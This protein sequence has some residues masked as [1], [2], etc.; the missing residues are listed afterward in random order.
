MDYKVSLL[1]TST[2]YPV[3]KQ[4]LTDKAYVLFLYHTS[5]FMVSTKNQLHIQFA[6]STHRTDA[7]IMFY[8]QVAFN[9]QQHSATQ[10]DRN[11]TNFANH[12]INSEFIP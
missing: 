7:C 1:L 6:N 5:D 3:T 8:L 2:K 10:H 4:Y 9:S 11:A 12:L